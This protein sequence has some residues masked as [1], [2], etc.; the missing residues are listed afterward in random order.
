MEYRTVS[1]IL[2]P[3]LSASTLALGLGRDTEVL[4]AHGAN[5]SNSSLG[6]ALAQ[7]PKANIALHPVDAPLHT[8]ALPP[9][10]ANRRD[11][12]LRVKLED[13]VLVDTAQLT[14]A[15]QALG[16]NAFNVSAV[17]TTLLAQ[18][19]TALEALGHSQRSV[20]A[21]AAHL[22]LD[23]AQ[24]LG[25]WTLYRDAQGA[26]AVPH[27]TVLQAHV[28]GS[29]ANFLADSPTEFS[30]S[31][32]I[33]FGKNSAPFTA[34]QS[35]RDVWQRWRWAALLAGLCAAVYIASTWLHWRNVLAVQQQA[36]R[37]A[38]TAFEQAMPNTPVS[39]MVKQLKA[40]ATGGNA[41]TNTLENIPADW[42]QGAVT[43]M[44]WS[45]KRLSITVNAA[46]LKLNPAQQTLMAENLAGK[47][48]AVTWSKP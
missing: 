21:L 16:K 25:A 34:T 14:L 30:P 9:L 20:V 17:R 12:A 8:I 10:S 35:N 33:N 18:V 41:L 5:M 37:S 28:D 43:Q 1:L 24:S 7:H 29:P 2:L 48:I 42:V 11:A 46:L 4:V 19:S 45:N 15:V 13:A 39:D 44:I 40:A 31:R 36:Q 3:P 32:L 47:N 26:G 38:Q 23:S 22:P 6:L 27:Q